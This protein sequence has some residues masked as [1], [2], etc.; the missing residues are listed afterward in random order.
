MFNIDYQLELKKAIANLY[1]VFEPYRLN[2]HIAGCPCCV[3]DDDQKSIRSKVLDRLTAKDLDHY[4]FNAIFTWGTIEDFKH[5]LPRLLEITAF[6]P[7]FFWS[8]T[9]ITKLSYAEFDNWREEEQKVTNRYLIALWNYILSQ[10]PRLRFSAYDFIDSLLSVNN[11][12]NIFLAMWQNHSSSFSL[13]HLSEFISHRIDFNEVPIK[14][15]CF[16]QKHTE[17]FLQWLS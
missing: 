1:E 3:T 5:F 14:I 17:Q 11:E 10:P 15:D 6:E 13:L 4:A 7:K 12:L 9:V 16:S 8:D 2:P